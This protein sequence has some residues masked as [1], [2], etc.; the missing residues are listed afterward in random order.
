MDYNITYRQK[1]GGWQY[2]VSFKDEEGKWRQRAKQGFRTRALAKKAADKR[3]EEIKKELSQKAQLNKEYEGITFKEFKEIHLKEL[4]LYREPNTVTTHRVALDKFNDLDDKELTDITFMDIKNIVNDMLR[5]GLKVSTIELY[6]SRLRITLNAAVDEYKIIPE[7]PLAKNKISLPRSKE[8]N[9]IKAL[10]SEELEKL[11][12]LIK[13]EKDRMIALIASKCGLRAGEIIGLTWDDVDFDNMDL[14]VNKQWKQLASGKYG[15]GSLKTKNSYRKVPIPV[16]VVTELKKYKKSSTREFKLDRIFPEKSTSIMC[17]RF[18]YK[19]K[20]LGF[21]ISLHDLRHTY[22]THL[23]AI[24]LDFKTIAE[25]MGDTVEMV[26]KTYAHFNED[27]YEA[28]RAK[29]NKF[30]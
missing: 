20:S 7:N 27:M 13:P 4:A 22:A 18:N 3:V 15:F 17:T 10:T 11:L 5:E 30:L 19:F 29:I 25:Y 1:D 24:G 26:I 28:G 14:S 6:L 23:I 9:K 21:N 16:N 12:S 2:I 8:A